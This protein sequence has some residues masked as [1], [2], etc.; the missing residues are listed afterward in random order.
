MQWE[1]DSLFNKRCWE[2][3]IATCKRMILDHFVRL[4]TKINSKWIKE[5]TVRPETIKILEESTGSNFSDINC[6]N[7]FVNRSSEARETKAK[8]NYWDYIKIKR[9]CTARKQA[10]LC[11][12]PFLTFSIPQLSAC[13]WGIILLGQGTRAK[14]FWKHLLMPIY[15]N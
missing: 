7:I 3:W 1:K 8:M 5:L 6:S 10:V 4:Y 15:K 12:P 14:D 2:K 9:F 13:T 11:I